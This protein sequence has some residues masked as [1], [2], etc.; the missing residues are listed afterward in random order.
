MPCYWLMNPRS[1]GITSAKAGDAVAAAKLVDS[2]VGDTAIAA[3]RSLIARV[4]EDGAPGL[5]SAHAYERQGI[6]AIPATL[7]VFPS[8]QLGFPFKAHVV[9]TDIVSHTGA[10]GYGRLARQAMFAGD[11]DGGR[12][13]VMVDDFMG[14]GGT[15]RICGAG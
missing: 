7:A 4:S 6:N 13:H 8:E 15:L 12:E 10:D 2:L 1:S 5:V 14:Q 11:V 3:V 9:Q